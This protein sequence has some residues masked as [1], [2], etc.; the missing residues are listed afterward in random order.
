[1]LSKKKLTRS[2]RNPGKIS[3]RAELRKKK[4][5]HHLGKNWGVFYWIEE[6]IST[7]PHGFCLRKRLCSP[8]RYVISYSNAPQVL[9]VKDLFRSVDISWV[10]NKNNKNSFTSKTPHFLT[11]GYTPIVTGLAYEFLLGYNEELFFDQTFFL[12]QVSQFFV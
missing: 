7:L 6:R 12:H 3:K 2:L 10:T 5:V 11:S 1:M 8:G 4:E 9:S